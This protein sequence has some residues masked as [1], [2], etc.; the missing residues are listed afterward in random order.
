MSNK[1]ELSGGMF[2]SQHHS[3]SY[4]FISPLHLDLSGKSIMVTGTAFESG[5][6]FAAATAF[7]RAGASAIA[8]ADLHGVSAS[9]VAK[10]KSEAT[11]ARR[12][13][14]NVISY[15]VDIAKPE[16]VEKL[17]EAFDRDFGGR[18]DILVNNA[19]HMEPYESFLQS[20]PD[21]S[22]RTWEVNVHGLVNMARAFLPMLLASGDSSNGLRTMVNV[23]SSGALTV[24]P[25]SA[26]YRTSKL[27]VLRWTEALQV[28]Y[29]DQGLLAYCVNPGAIKTEITRV[30]PE[31]ARNALPDRPDVAGD[32]IAWLAAE[33][34]EWLGGRYIS[35]PWDME[36]LMQ[37]KE[38]IVSGDKLKLKLVL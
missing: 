8:V 10:L 14:P 29:A 11:A 1:A 4:D 35:C 5:V 9:L 38:E 19:A 28:E 32:T 26:S 15:T 13:E 31:A 17:R 27:A 21:V 34:K 20:D 23:S 22:W 24:R 18:L 33:R 6:G 2:T 16:S 12:R 30:V 37:K 3:T 7:A 36:E 25:G